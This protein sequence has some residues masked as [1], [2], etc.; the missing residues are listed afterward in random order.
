MFTN[1]QF[2]KNSEYPACKNCKHYLED[3]RWPNEPAFAKCTLFGEKDLLSGK[4][5]NYDLYKS[6]LW[7]DY[8]GPD[9]KH[10]VEIIKEDKLKTFCEKIEKLFN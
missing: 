2:I 8:C 10:F 9:G 6:R 4:V 3:K 5:V 1:N 7:N